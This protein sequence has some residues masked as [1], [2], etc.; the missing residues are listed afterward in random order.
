MPEYLTPGVY[1]EFVDAA[2]PAVFGARV[3]VCG[4]IGIAQRGPLHQPVRIESWRQFQ[5]EYGNFVPYAYLAYTVYAFFE[6]GGRTCYAVRV[7]GADAASAQFVL[8]NPAGIPV[9]GVSALNEGTWGNR[10]AVTLTE[11]KPAASLFSLLITRDLLVRESFQNL[12]L[13]PGDK[14]YF[15]HVINDGIE[16]TA[17]SQ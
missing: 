13:N 2:P 4:I 7:A 12:S 5:A 8:K 1:F 11:V 14:N 9:I 10:V 6:N 15:L 16:R 17:A 3:D